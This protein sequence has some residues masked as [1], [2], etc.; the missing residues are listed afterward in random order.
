MIDLHAHTNESDGTFSPVELIDA[1]SHT[2]VTVLGITDHD[3]F[4]GYDQALPHA[5]EQGIELICGI[6]LSTK[7]GGQSVHLLAYYLDGCPTESRIWIDEMQASRDERNVRLIECLRK[8]GI[9]ITL[10]EV[11]AKGRRMAGRPHFAQVLVE[12]GYVATIQEA[13]DKYLDKSAPYHVDRDEPQLV[14]CI[15]RVRDQRG[16]TSLAHPYRLKGDLNGILPELCRHGLNAIEVYHSDHTAMQTEQF[17][18]LAE[19]YGLGITGGSDFH[20]AVKPDIKLGS[21]RL[22]NLKIPSDLLVSLRDSV[23]GHK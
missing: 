11:R 5:R 13:F 8:G 17:F 10:E 7:F 23:H 15:E 1:A 16:I 9:A 2:G 14:S 6:E 19:R 22:G 3:T 21:G 4:A 20:G 12:K 18:Q